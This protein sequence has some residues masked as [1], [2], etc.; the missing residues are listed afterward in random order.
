MGD[1]ERD[2]FFRRPMSEPLSL[3]LPSECFL[4]LAASVSDSLSETSFLSVG[5]ASEPGLLDLDLL[6]DLVL[7]LDLDGDLEAAG[8][9]DLA[10]VGLPE[11]ER[12]GL[13]DLL[14]AGEPVDLAGLADLDFGDSALDLGDPPSADLGEPVLD[15]GLPLPDFGDLAEEPSDLALTDLEQ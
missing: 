7:D 2:F 8:L 4:F 12:A 11:L 9:L 15:L 6:G 10:R 13:P 3:P 14:L 1:L 5:S